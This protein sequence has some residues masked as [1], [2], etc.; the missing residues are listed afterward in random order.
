MSFPFNQSDCSVHIQVNEKIDYEKIR[1]TNILHII[2]CCIIFFPDLA[3]GMHVWIG[4]R[5]DVT[6]GTWLWDDGTLVCLRIKEEI[7]L[8]KSLIHLYPHIIIVFVVFLI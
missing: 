5:D 4:L 1:R 6:E 8:H 3:G 2:L 7:D